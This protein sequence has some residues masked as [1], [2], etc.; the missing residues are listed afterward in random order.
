MRAKG[1]G[2]PEVCAANLLKI[3]RGEVSYD[4]IRG[5]DGSLIDQPGVEDEA[6]ADTEWVLQTYEPRVDVKTIPSDADAQVGDFDSIVE[7]TARREDEE[8]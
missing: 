7:I 6:A 2:L 4:R 1:N 5:R 3:I 8:M